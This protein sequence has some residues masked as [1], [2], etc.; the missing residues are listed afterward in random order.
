MATSTPS[1]SLYHSN[2]MFPLRPGYC[3]AKQLNSS[4]EDSS[5]GRRDDCPAVG[6]PRVMNLIQHKDDDT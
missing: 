3:E 5:K 2:V 4:V 6:T 1:S